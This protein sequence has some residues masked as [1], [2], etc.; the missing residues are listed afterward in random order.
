MVDLLDPITIMGGMA[1]RRGMQ[2]SSVFNRLPKS[3]TLIASA[4]SVFHPE[5]PT[6]G[7]EVAAH[8]RQVRFG[9]VADIGRVAINVSFGPKAAGRED[10][11][12]PGMTSSA[13]IVDRV[14]PP[15]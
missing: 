2:R 5:C 10:F 7:A 11:S 1:P 13:D 6:S 3:W 15:H 9:S 8:K 14:Q 12:T 4:L